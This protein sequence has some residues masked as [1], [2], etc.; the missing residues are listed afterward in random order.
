MSGDKIKLDEASL[1]FILNFVLK[2]LKED[3]HLA[4]QHHDTLA[5]LLQG[6]SG[7]GSG[8][9]I[10]LMVQ[11]LSSALTNFLNSASLSTERAIKIAKILS[12]ILVKSDADT[13]LSDDER[14][15]I[16]GMIGGL[17]EE[18]DNIDSVSNILELQQTMSNE[19][20]D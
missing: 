12:D 2:N 10:Q 9:E 5:S 17:Q 18:K 11:E 14:A 16:E 3:R 8:L 20:N 13:T 1:E 15:E 4:L 19:S 6:T 7:E